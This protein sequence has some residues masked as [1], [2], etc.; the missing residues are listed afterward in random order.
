MRENNR[1]HVLTPRRARRARDRREIWRTRRIDERTY[2]RT[3]IRKYEGTAGVRA[4]V[5]TNGRTNG[6]Y[7]Q[8]RR[9]RRRENARGEPEKNRL[10][11]RDDDTDANRGAAR[12]LSHA[13]C[14]ASSSSPFVS[15]SLPLS[16]ARSLSLSR[17]FY[18]TRG[19]RISRTFPSGRAESRVHDARER[20][21]GGAARYCTRDEDYHRVGSKKRETG[22]RGA[23]TRQTRA[24]DI[25]T[26]MHR[27]QKI[28][29]RDTAGT[30]GG[31]G[32]P[33]YGATR[34]PQ[35]CGHALFSACADDEVYRRARRVAVSRS[36]PSSRG[37]AMQRDC[38]SLSRDSTWFDSKG[39]T[40]LG[41][42]K[43]ENA[44]IHEHKKR[45]CGYPRM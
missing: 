34:K 36:V 5:R 6:T 10:T 42:R 38:R 18:C 31:R 2:V 13:L 12:Y 4:N 7:R 43:R 40:R 27:E 28:R 19:E 21:N 8:R 14:L 20:S 9:R 39:E 37:T 1:L 45:T 25:R 32:E 23:A 30:P 29:A 22:G 26:V 33:H 16:L 44:Q 17:S 15:L 35:R 41:R 3:D 11:T 24:C